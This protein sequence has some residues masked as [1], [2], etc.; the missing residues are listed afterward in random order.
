MVLAR[1]YFHR[2]SLFCKPDSVPL[3]V[4]PRPQT[5]VA[6]APVVVGRFSDASR[7]IEP[8]SP[9]IYVEL[10]DRLNETA[11]ME[12]RTASELRR[13]VYVQGDDPYPAGDEALFYMRDAEPDRETLYVPGPFVHLWADYWCRHKNG[14][15]EPPNRSPLHLLL[16]ALLV[17]HSRGGFEPEE[18]YCECRGCAHPLR[19]VPDEH[20]ECGSCGLHFLCRRRSLGIY[21]T[22][23]PRKKYCADC[24]REPC[25]FGG[26]LFKGYLKVTGVKCS[27]CNR[28]MG[29]LNRGKRHGCGGVLCRKCCHLDASTCPSC[30][31]KW[32]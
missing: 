10:H 11:D 30:D 16:K 31:E 21:E 5:S 19:A 4:R 7:R 8:N 29:N 20:G 25:I 24:R 26:R 9:A 28:R 3:C 17:L 1:R 2:T 27:G 22:A 15:V 14:A 32:Y 23:A 13:R 12:R 6:T 18:V